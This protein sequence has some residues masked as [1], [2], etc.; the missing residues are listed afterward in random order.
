[1]LE[2]LSLY[3]TPYHPDNPT[4]HQGRP[5]IQGDAPTAYSDYPDVLK[6]T[7]STGAVLIALLCTHSDHPTMEYH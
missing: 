3:T 1:M 5:S 6:L 4:N 2:L 7:S